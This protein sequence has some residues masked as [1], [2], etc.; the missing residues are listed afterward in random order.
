M[1]GHRVG[2]KWFAKTLLHSD[3]RKYYR[4]SWWLYSFACHEVLSFFHLTSIAHISFKKPWFK[5]IFCKIFSL[6]SFLLA[7]KEALSL[8]PISNPLWDPFLHSYPSELNF[9]L[10]LL[11]FSS[12]RW[13]VASSYKT[14]TC[15]ANAQAKNNWKKTRCNFQS[16]V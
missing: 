6:A 8:L 1:P 2:F 11:A 12:P 4:F 7:V 15:R 10:P 9:C 5:Q 16:F 3:S 14:V 13:S